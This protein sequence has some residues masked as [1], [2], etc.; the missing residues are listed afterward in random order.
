MM[1]TKKKTKKTK[2]KKTT[3]K[4]RAPAVIISRDTPRPDMLGNKIW[5]LRRT[6]GRNPIFKT[7]AQ[8]WN[9]CCEYFVWND[10]NPLIEQKL[11]SY[12][13]GVVTGEINKMR[14]MTKTGLYLFIGI[15]E[16]T[17]RNL[18][19]R[20]GFTEVTVKVEDVMY[21]QKF[22]GAA[23][24]MLNPHIIIRELGL[25]DKKEVE[26]IKSVH[27]MSDEELK[28]HVRMLEAK[29]KKSTQD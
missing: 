29:N 2:T 28:R 23:A 27:D 12:Q 17:W 13:G 18:R 8:L 6:T 21:D 1:K 22:T 25:V 14:A 4:I 19:E 20:K 9:A 5:M 26:E 24:D 15:A 3:R 11:F 7:P 10:A 16:G